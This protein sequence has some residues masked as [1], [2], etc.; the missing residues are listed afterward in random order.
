MRG[1]KALRTVL[2]TAI[3]LVTG[4]YLWSSGSLTRWTLSLVIAQIEMY[5]MDLIGAS[6][7]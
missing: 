5:G 3:V 1:M 7:E 2:F 4:I 6:F